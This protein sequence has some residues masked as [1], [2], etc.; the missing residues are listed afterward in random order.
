MKL[1]HSAEHYTHATVVSN[2]VDDTH[3][4]FVWYDATDAEVFG[5]GAQSFG[6]FKTWGE[7]QLLRYE[8]SIRINGTRRLLGLSLVSRQKL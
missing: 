7:A 8:I 6:P 2:E 1:N 3:R 4:V 5:L